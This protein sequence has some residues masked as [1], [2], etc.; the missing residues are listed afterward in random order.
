MAIEDLR[1]RGYSNVRKQWGV[2]LWFVDGLGEG[3]MLLGREIQALGL[4]KQWP[5][6]MKA[7]RGIR[8]INEGRRADSND[9]WPTLELE[10]VPQRRTPCFT[11][12]DGDLYWLGVG[13]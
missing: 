8:R 2:Q 13:T 10:Y 5:W 11:V 6:Y 1:L 3:H 7:N 9:T 12:I 4:D